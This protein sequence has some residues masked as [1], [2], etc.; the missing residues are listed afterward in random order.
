MPHSVSVSD[1]TDQ[2]LADGAISREAAGHLGTGRTITVPEMKRGFE[3]VVMSCFLIDAS[4]SMTPFVD[5]VVQGQHAALEALRGSAKC[6][7]A[8]LYVGQWLFSSDVKLLNPFTLLEK[9]GNDS[10]LLLGPNSY[11]PQDGDGTA[12]YATVLHVLQDMAANM[13]YALS[14]HIRTTFT[15]ALITDGEDNCGGASSSQIATV[16]NDL[17]SQGHL[18]K[19]TLIGI[20]SP[21]FP[22]ANIEALQRELGFDELIFA[23]QDPRE[24]R[25][26]FALASQSAVRAQA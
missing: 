10:V 26:A 3:D 1:A 8:A 11:R 17:R 21:D 13:A 16:V 5:A 22:R 15:M 20:E 25:R 6:R 14:Q 19:A 9:G 24:I 7:K 18:V 4:P 2:L 23:G 12:L